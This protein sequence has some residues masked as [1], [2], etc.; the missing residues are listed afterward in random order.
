MGDQ[1]WAR[2]EDFSAGM[3]ALFADMMGGLSV[4]ELRDELAASG[5]DVNATVGAMGDDE[6]QEA[7]ARRAAPQ[8]AAAHNNTKKQDGEQRAR[9]WVC[10]AA[11]HWALEGGA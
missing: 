4:E 3:D 11:S 2:T 1:S 9:V 5:A 8:Q 6:R 10:I 7:A